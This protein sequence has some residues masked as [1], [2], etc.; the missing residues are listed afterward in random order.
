M[1]YSTPAL[2]TAPLPIH[3]TGRPGHR[4]A[5][6][7][8]SSGPGAFAPLG[9]LPRR[10][11]RKT[12]FHLSN[13]D[14]DD[15]DDDTTNSPDDSHDHDDDDVLHNVPPALKL[16]PNNS[17]RLAIYTE[18][19][20]PV[21]VRTSTVTSSTTASVPFPTCPPHY[22]PP[23]TSIPTP[24]SPGS[25]PSRPT[26]PRTT[27]TPIFLSNGKPLKSSLKSSSSSPHITLP[28]PTTPTAVTT[29]TQPLPNH[30]R[31]RSAPSTPNIDLPPVHK[32][33]HFPSNEDGGLATVRIF[34]RSGKPASLSRPNNG[35]DTETETEGELST[36][37]GSTGFIRGA[38]AMFPFPRSP[39]SQDKPLGATA[40]AAALAS[41]SSVK[42]EVDPAQSSP[43]P[44]TN[45]P[46]YANVHLESLSYNVAGTPNGK[47][48][49]G[50]SGTLLV[51]NIAYEKQ[52]A[53]RF[54]LDDWQTTSEVSAKHLS[55]LPAL[56]SS[57]STN[58]QL[59][60]GDIIALPTPTAASTVN[61]SV[62]SPQW[63]R[64]TFHIKLEDYA[65]KLAQ[66][67]LFLVVRYTAGSPGNGSVESWDNNA[68]S[69]YKIAFREASTPAA[70][71]ASK[72]IAIPQP[73]PRG[74]V[75]AVS[76]PREF[77]FSL[78]SQKR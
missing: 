23:M 7:A 55:S 41:S 51:R 39:L 37:S 71:A 48:P 34:N 66:R 69:N 21:P 36:G 62:E 27:S 31:A 11:P 47:I 30:L 38:S 65:F 60:F 15:D 8:P 16:K 75:F 43:I 49:P 19:D 61:T 6:T 10:R 14:D 17:L 50:L 26:V 78:S 44:A 1:P 74:R 33:V 5:Y 18:D 76:S 63:D 68:G 29:T 67:T 58:Q 4:R 56:P 77:Y 3:S 12:V 22:S 73:N 59:T 70:V 25:I 54:T 35:D 28:S 20:T 2:P 45:P 40:S 42:Y 64:F 46:S 53:V 72:P 13:D 24:P 9:I 57:F 32:N 52:V